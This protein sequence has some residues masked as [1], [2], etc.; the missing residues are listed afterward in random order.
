MF[1]I[2][3]KYISKYGDIDDYW[4]EIH[5]GDIQEITNKF[6]DND[7]EKLYKALPAKDTSWKCKLMS[8]IE[9]DTKNI[10]KVS[11]L[12]IDTND[13]LL[14]DYIISAFNFYKYNIMEDKYLLFNPTSKMEFINKIIDLTKKVDAIYRDNFT[15]FLKNANDNSNPESIKK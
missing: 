5:V 6:T 7:W 3:D 8:G 2:L 14:L 13:I 10:L 1:E 9:G 11:S 12:M 15:N 4:Y